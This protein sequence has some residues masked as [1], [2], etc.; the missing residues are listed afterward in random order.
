MLVAGLV[1]GTTAD[2]G[3]GDGGTAVATVVEAG[4]GVAMP[5]VAVEALPLPEAVDMACTVD[6]TDVATASGVAATAV[7]CAILRMRGQTTMPPTIRQATVMSAP[8]MM[9]TQGRDDDDLLWRP[10][11]LGGGGRRVGG[12]R[13]GGLRVGMGVS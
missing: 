9:T 3:V 7:G 5:G 10:L 2:E 12:R 11:G 6:A 13:G 4:G 8:P 1:V